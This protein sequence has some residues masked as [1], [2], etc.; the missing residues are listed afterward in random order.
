MASRVDRESTWCDSSPL[1]RAARTVSR[2]CPKVIRPRIGSRPASRSS[3]VRG[4]GAYSNTHSNASN[5]GAGS[6][7]HSSSLLS[8]RALKP[9]VRAVTRAGYVTGRTAARFNILSSAGGNGRRKLAENNVQWTR[10]CRE[11]LNGKTGTSIT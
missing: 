1:V 4:R 10:R 8:A 7:G 5:S 9:Q 6:C 3:A 11:A 2:Y